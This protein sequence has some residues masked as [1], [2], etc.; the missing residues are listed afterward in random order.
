MERIKGGARV[1]GTR[2]EIELPFEETHVH[3]ASSC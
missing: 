3:A 2:V 1:R